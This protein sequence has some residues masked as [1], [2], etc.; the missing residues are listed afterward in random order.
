MP[1]LYCRLYSRRK[2]GSSERLV[3][4]PKFGLLLA[5]ISLSCAMPSPFGSLQLRLSLKL[6]TG[7]NRLAKALDSAR[8]YLPKLAFTAVLPLAN[9][10]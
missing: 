4:L 5:A 8:M 6:A 2:F 10:S 7:L 3:I 9:T 1:A